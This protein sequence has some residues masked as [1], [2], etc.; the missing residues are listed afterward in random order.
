[1]ATEQTVTF[2]YSKGLEISVSLMDLRAALIHDQR[3]AAQEGFRGV[4]ARAA[5][6][7]AEIDAAVQENESAGRVSWATIV[8]KGSR[9]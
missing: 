8:I 3:I 5:E 9:L 1:M 2:T 7:L 4:S 6:V